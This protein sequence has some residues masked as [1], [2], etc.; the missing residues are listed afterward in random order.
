MKKHY[1]IASVAL[2]LAVGAFLI[3]GSG[4]ASG[5]S[6]TMYKSPTCGCCVGNAQV[7][8]GDGFDV[9]VVPSENLATI[10]A[11]KNIPLEMQSC[12]TSMVGGYFVEGHVP[13]EAIEKLLTE[14][15]DIDGI[16]LPGM[17]AG[18]SGM[19]GT[20]NGEWIIYSLKNGE[21]SEFMRI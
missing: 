11:Q 17:P 21:Y 6:L 18:S 5:T 13:T 14:K 16:A 3:F 8:T 9:K 19:P 1:L 4:G 20:K 10:K 12:H 2:I 15:P 7:L